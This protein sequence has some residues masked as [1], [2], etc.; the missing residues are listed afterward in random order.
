MYNIDF[1]K[2]VKQILPAAL[3]SRSVID[4]M[5]SF[6]HPLQA[7]NYLFRSYRDEKL[8]DLSYTPQVASLQK[9]L[10]D[11]VD[12]ASR[13]VRVLDGLTNQGRRVRLLQPSGAPDKRQLR[14]IFTISPVYSFSERNYFTVELPVGMSADRI[15][16]A[17]KLIERYKMAGT[18]YKIVL[19]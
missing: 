9:L 13:R 17:I 8:S 11:R 12:Y 10:N 2:L 6:V 4:Y 5:Y 1:K 19:M 18:R 7:S 14:V 3:R 15:N 16:Q